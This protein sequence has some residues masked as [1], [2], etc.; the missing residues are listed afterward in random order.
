MPPRPGGVLTF[1][2]GAPTADVLIIGHVGFEPV[3]SIKRLRQVLPLRQPVEVKMW[4][5][6]RATVPEGDE[7]RL[8]WIYDR[9]AE[10]DD[11]IDE[12]K[13]ARA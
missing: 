1:L 10:L 2:D 8:D 3:A 12:R 11:W 9:W 4:R 13:Q 7:A 6:A 5:H